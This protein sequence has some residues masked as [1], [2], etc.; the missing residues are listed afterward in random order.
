LTSGADY[1][2]ITIAATLPVVGERKDRNLFIDLLKVID[3]KCPAAKFTKIYVIADNYRIHTAK[4]VVEWLAAHPRFEVVSLPS[5][6]P[7]EPD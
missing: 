1:T 5:Y 6:C 7:R 2:R 3:W 4:A